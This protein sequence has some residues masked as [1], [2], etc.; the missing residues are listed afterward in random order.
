MHLN[1]LG[2]RIVVINTLKSAIDLLDRKALST[3]R[4]PRNIVVGIMTNNLMFAFI[5]PGKTSILLPSSPLSPHNANNS[6]RWKRMRRASHDGL[7]SGV[8]SLL[9]PSLYKEGIV[10]SLDLVTQLGAT[11]LSP[12]CTDTSKHNQKAV[13]WHKQLQR[14]VTIATTR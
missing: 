7:R 1:A 6:R 14:L 3:S 9:L 11:S 8:I 5:Q 10:L 4:R 2:Q 12:P 13:E